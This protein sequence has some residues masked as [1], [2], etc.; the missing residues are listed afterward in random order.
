MSDVRILPLPVVLPGLAGDATAPMNDLAAYA[1]L[2]AAS[3]LAATLLP[4][5]SEAVLLGLVLGGKQSASL[6][7]AVATVGNVGGSALNW[8]IG[9]S[10]ERL[11]DR[12]W[13]PVSPKALSRAQDRFRRFGVW[14]LLLSWLPFVGD[15]ITLAAGMLRVPLGQFLLLVFLGKAGRYIVLTVATLHLA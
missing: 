14:S 11:R 4:A 6:L 10:V 13:F 9:R 15:P 2:L 7:V 12:W 1:G 3:F 5:Q 8:L